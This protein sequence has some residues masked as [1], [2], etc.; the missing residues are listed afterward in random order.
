LTAFEVWLD[1]GSEGKKSPEQL[2]IVLQV[3]HCAVTISYKSIP[4]VKPSLTLIAF[5]LC[6]S[7]PSLWCFTFFTI[8]ENGLHALP[9]YLMLFFFLFFFPS[10][11]FVLSCRSSLVNHTDLER[12]FCLEDFL[13]WDHGQLI[14]FVAVHFC[15][16]FF[17]EMIVTYSLWNPQPL[18]LH[19]FRLYL[20][21]SSLMYSNCFKQV[22][23]SCVK[24]LCSYGQKFSLLTRY[25]R[26][27]IF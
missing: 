8:W 21:E 13:T 24:F 20:L 10:Y 17:K 5:S 15:M 3:K 26:F 12:L 27:G 25:V 22:R 1:H 16:Y 23:W 9:C 4:F 11:I 2:P 6:T 7:L 19:C 18:A 14:W